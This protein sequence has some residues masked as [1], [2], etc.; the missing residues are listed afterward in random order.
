[1]YIPIKNNSWIYS[2]GGQFAVDRESIRQFPK[3]F[4]QE[5]YNWI[6][7]LGPG[8][9]SDDFTSLVD[10]TKTP[11]GGFSTASF[12]NMYSDGQCRFFFGLECILQP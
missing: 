11:R 7:A 3:V 2:S 5:I 8:N 1:M 4:Y 10:S 9:N 12:E 6:M